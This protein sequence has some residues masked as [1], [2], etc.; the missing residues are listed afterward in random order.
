MENI[1]LRRTAPKRVQPQRKEINMDDN[2][3]LPFDT[4]SL[5]LDDYPDMDLEELLD[6]F[7]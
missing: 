1:L 6:L 4:E 5:D 3:E 7:E 2:V